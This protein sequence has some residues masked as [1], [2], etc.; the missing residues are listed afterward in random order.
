MAAGTLSTSGDLSTRGFQQ[1]GGKLDV[2]R[3]FT[4]T[5]ARGGVALGDVTAGA[6]IAISRGGAITQIAGTGINVS[7][8]ARFTADNGGSGTGDVRYAI[9]L[10]NAAN[11]FVSPVATAGSNVSLAD[12]SGGLILGY[13][14]AIG[15]LV[16]RS[17][18]GAITQVAGAPFSVS[19]SARFTADNGVSGAGDVRYGITLANA[20][21]NFMGSIAIAGSN[22]DLAEQGG[23]FILGYTSVT[24]AL[25]LTSLGS[26]ITQIA[27]APF[28]VTGTTRLTADNGA[29]GAGDVRYN[30]TL[31]NAANR[32]GG[33]V[34]A[35]GRAVTLDDAGALTASVNSTGATSLESA[36]SLAVSGTIGTDLTTVSTGGTGS[37]T[38]F[39]TTTVGNDLNV[40]SPG[41]VTTVTPSTALQ[42]HGAGTQ[43][44]NSHVTVNHVSGAL[45]E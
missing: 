4:I 31:S 29:S 21:N 40:T 14:R 38:T 7:G 5:S 35:T 45:I 9:T 32:F 3:Y 24:G 33:E 10:D 34:F 11:N 39:G 8:S 43:T 20:S 13:T 22:V 37:T 23:R 26:A 25:T 16:V 18:G 17:S 28:D 12:D 2:G 27:G 6:L 15:T 19:G 1:T 30:V 36:G 42:V 44:P 41:A